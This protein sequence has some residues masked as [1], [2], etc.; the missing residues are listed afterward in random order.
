V[1]FFLTDHGVSHIRGKQFLYDEGIRVPLIIRFPDGRMANTKRND[2]TIH[3]DLAPTSL[4][5]AG[6]EIPK[7]FQGHDIFAKSSTNRDFIIA[8]R[9]ELK[10]PGKLKG[11][12]TFF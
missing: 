12:G 5:L 7:H 9:G 2:L 1:I 10:T 4:A 8:A 6:I 3:I 11:Y